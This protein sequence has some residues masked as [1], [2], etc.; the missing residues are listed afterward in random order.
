MSS[1]YQL[2]K[3][4]VNNITMAIFAL[5]LNLPSKLFVNQKNNTSHYEMYKQW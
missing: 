4:Y 1:I 2:R 3:S 5:E